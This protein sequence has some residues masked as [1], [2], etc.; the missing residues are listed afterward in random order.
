MCRVASKSIVWA[1]VISTSLSSRLVLHLF[2]FFTFC[3]LFEHITYVMELTVTFLTL[4]VSHR[5]W[6][7]GTEPGS[8]AGVASVFSC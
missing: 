3:V 5:V 2:C 4:V 6:I 8:F 7:P 1:E